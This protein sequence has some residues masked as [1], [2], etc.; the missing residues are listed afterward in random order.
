[1][2]S[3]RSNISS[4]A[5]T[6][7][8]RSALHAGLLTLLNPWAVNVDQSAILLRSP[9]SLGLTTFSLLFR[10]ICLPSPGF[11][12]FTRPLPPHLCHSRRYSPS[13]ASV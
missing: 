7:F 1:M 12:Y 13:P 6:A 11:T 3:S 10:K 8:L 4:R 5:L 9:R 2:S